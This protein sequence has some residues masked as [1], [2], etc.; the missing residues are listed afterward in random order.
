LNTAS[1]C[2]KTIKC[3]WNTCFAAVVAKRQF[4]QNIAFYLCFAMVAVPGW[5]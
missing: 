3:T 4:K 2:I 5:P 1:K